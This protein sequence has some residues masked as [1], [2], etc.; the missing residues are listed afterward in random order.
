MT[1]V[2]ESL[3]ALKKEEEDRRAAI[4]KQREIDDANSKYRMEAAKEK[5]FAALEGFEVVD[6]SEKWHEQVKVIFEGD[7]RLVRIQFKPATHSVRYCDDYGPEDVQVIEILIHVSDGGPFGNTHTTTSPEG[8]STAFA[9][10]LR[11]TGLDR[12]L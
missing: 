12:S 9:K 8:F 4:L 2:R 7:T 6:I 1:T 10:V 3:L 11:S 5:V